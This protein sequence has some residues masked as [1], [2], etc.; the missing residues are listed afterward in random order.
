[1]IIVVNKKCIE[2]NCKTSATFNILSETKAIY[3]KKHK[4][5]N[6]INIKS[7]RCKEKGCMIIP[8]FNLV[9]ETKP[10][11]CSKHKQKNMV[12]IKHTKCIEDKC[13]SRPMFN[14]STDSKPIYCNKHK[15]ENMI[16]I[17]SK[18]C[19]EKDC[20]IQPNYNFPSLKLAIYCNKHKKNDMIDIKNIKCIQ[21]KCINRATY[22]IFSEKKA[23][24]CYEHKTKNMINV[25]NNKCQKS[26]CK[27]IP[28]F[29]LPNKR[30]QFCL[31]HKKSNMI[32]L[33]LENKC[34]ILECNEEYNHSIE[35]TK[36]CNT[37]IPEKS[38]IIIKKLCKFC[39]IKE[40]SKYICK[41]C[42]KI[43][44]KKEWAI[45]RY[46]RKVIDTKFEYNSSK[47]LQGCSK[48]RPDIYFELL[49][50]C[51]IVEI[52]EHQHMNY[53]DNCE[54]ARINEIVNGIG[55][56][57][58]II[59]RYN[60]DIVKNKNNVLAIKQIDRI[61]L[62]VKTIKDELIKD[63][64]TFIV[65]IIQLFYNDDFEEYKNIKEEN[66]TDLVCI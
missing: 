43:Q 52:D 7:K 63:Y 42:K 51:I 21:D 37:H 45:V 62:L 16:N 19:I 25:K 6:M 8:T 65:K 36:Y 41:D 15:K 12:D 55:G 34:S 49:K 61:Y 38:L 39:D 30:V 46:L 22:N 64:N 11:Y 2:L 14:I 66:I 31:K 23:L 40:E 58:V 10:I 44:N 56:K 60:P 3:C 47:M 57:S 32:N 35:N 13:I 18:K 9:T 33:V 24:Y 27:E 20:M 17:K 28:I 5:D 59:I 53:S 1:M 4:K 54:C 50:F 29:G 26:N 48:K